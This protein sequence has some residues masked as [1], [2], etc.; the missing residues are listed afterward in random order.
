MSSESNNL[1]KTFTALIDDAGGGGA[2]VLIPFD[3]EKTFD[4]KR[5]KVRADIEGETY[6]GSLVRMG[7]DCP[8]WT[9]ARISAK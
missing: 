9:S 7:T 3:V 8:S 2:Y 5:V 1:M 4:K 6:R